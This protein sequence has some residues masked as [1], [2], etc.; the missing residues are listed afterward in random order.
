MNIQKSFYNNL[1]TIENELFPALNN[2]T[3]LIC[4]NSIKTDHERL[5]KIIKNKGYVPITI[6]S[7]ADF[8]NSTIYQEGLSCMILSL[9]ENSFKVKKKSYENNVYNLNKEIINTMGEMVQYRSK[10]TSDH[11]KRVAVY[12]D[13]IAKKISLDKN[14]NE[15]LNYASPM[16]DIGKI[17]VSDL[18]L[19]K[20]GKLTKEEFELIKTHTTIG[21]NMLKHSNKPIL[22]AAATIAHQHHERWD[23]KGYPNNLAKEDIHLFGRI[24]AIADVF[25]ALSSPRVY[26]DSWDNNKIYELYKSE[27]EK[28]FDPQL[29]DIFLNNFEE[30]VRVRDNYNKCK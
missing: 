5:N 23:G 30:L 15:L 22:K 7:A 18:I 27:R 14:E 8:N 13:F 28:Q 26:K 17:A 12:S 16:H 1:I 21:F 20:P 3:F 6:T 10:E 11:V 29:T 4:W 24:T 25:D 2:H 19:N 9:P